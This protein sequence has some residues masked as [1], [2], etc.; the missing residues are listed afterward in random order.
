MKNAAKLLECIADLQL[1]SITPT[2][3]LEQ[4]AEL[5]HCESACVISWTLGKPET[6][7]TSQ[8]L[9][10]IQI[11]EKW[12]PW[13]DDLVLRNS[14]DQPRLLEDIINSSGG[15]DLPNDSPLKDPALLIAYLDSNP[16]ITLFAFRKNSS[17]N[18][19][20]G[21]DR[22]RL[23]PILPALAK[24]HNLHK[25]LT[26]AETRLNIANS[27][28]NG[29]PRAIIA[30]S[31]TGKIVKSNSAGLELLKNDMF[32]AKDGILKIDDSR[33]MQQLNDK[34]AEVRVLT[35]V[36]LNR[37]IWNRTFHSPQDGRS[38]QLMLRAFMLES[39]H[40]EASDD[41]RFVE[42]IIGSPDMIAAPSTAQLRDFY[43]FSN[44]QARVVL[45]LLE[46]NDI[47]TAA[48]KLHISINTIRSHVRGIYE[49]L[50]VDNQ[51]DLLRLLSRTLVDY[52]SN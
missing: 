25:K 27:A 30:L 39:W 41:D 43:D 31:P 24:A 21:D 37:F 20:N 23:V 26:L 16:A 4:M 49:K 40:L 50:G 52:R 36:S 46:G 42:L 5:A 32:N 35:P 11:S 14:P 2:E 38:Y 9:K 28:L 47:I 44:A 18:G 13:V 33:V 10:Q 45:A 17:G 3:W 6:A 15:I 48:A 12:L 22:K 1:G 8:S 19:W 29:I 7:E 51:R 34:L